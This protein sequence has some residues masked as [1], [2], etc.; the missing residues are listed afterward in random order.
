MAPDAADV[1][2]T[3]AFALFTGATI[4]GESMTPIT[5]EWLRRLRQEDGQ[6]LVEYALII[7]FISVA[8]VASLG[9]LA[10]GL[11]ELITNAADVFA[12]FGS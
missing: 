8:L 9:L 3:G 6:T 2:T 10:D 1:A 11:S 4:A 12:G 5:R 7:L